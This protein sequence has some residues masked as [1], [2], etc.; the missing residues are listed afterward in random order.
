MPIDIDDENIEELARKL[1]ALTGESLEDVI[2]TALQR[3]YDRLLQE[4]SGAPPAHSDSPGEKL[5]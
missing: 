2:H 3:R 5:P 4:R 1:S